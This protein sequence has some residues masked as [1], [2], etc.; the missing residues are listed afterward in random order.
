MNTVL[1]LIEHDRTTLFVIGI[2][3]YRKFIDIKNTNN[4]N[5]IFNQS[6]SNI[7]NSNNNLFNYI[8]STIIKNNKLLGDIIGFLIIKKFLRIICKFIFFIQFK[9]FNELFNEI[10]SE[11]VYNLRQIPGISGI[12]EKEFKKVEDDLR[13][14]LKEPLGDPK[15]RERIYKLPENGIPQDI[16]IKKMKEFQVKEDKVWKNGYVSGGIYHGGDNILDLQCEAY[17]M[18]TISNPLHADLWPSVLKYEAEIISMTAN[19]LNGGDVRVCGVMSSGGTESIFMATK[20]HREW[21]KR[22]F[23][24]TKPEIICG[25]TAHA[26]I[27]KACEILNI[28]LIQAPVDPITR[29][30]NVD[31]VRKRITK[32]TIMIYSSAPC[33]PSGIIDDIEDLSNLA[34]EYGIG[35][36]VDCCLGGFILPFARKLGQ[37]YGIPKFDFE[38]GGVTSMSVDT[39]KYGYAPKGTSVVLYR[40]KGIRKY[41]YFTY[42]QWSGG[43]YVTPGT[44]GSRSGA[45]S[46]GAWATMLTLG[47]KGYLECTKKILDETK[48]I[49]EAVNNIEG[50]DVLGDP[51]AMIVAFS[52]NKFNIYTFNDLL[53]KKGWI[54][55]ALQFPASIHMC[56]TYKSAPYID[57]FIK[58]LQEC[59]IIML[60]QDNSSAKTG[61]APIYG[62]ASALPP[63]PIASVLESYVD[64]TLEV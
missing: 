3:L 16:V 47:E 48:K 33:F 64:V 23:N 63:G 62:M 46:A 2:I 19:L 31:A 58:D 60:K 45:L 57:Q 61:S 44:P 32:D 49:K 43:L 39:H 22:E 55:N 27:D 36:H 20:A 41:Q 30:V 51:K 18:Y 40:H 9:T 53:H 13:K 56:V 6:D 34:Q 54:L 21:F 29:K 26:A 11:V 52:S 35:L 15:T 10:M 1:S 4:V 25:Q 12:I 28:K 37:E 5:Q 7:I 38:L 24:I 8:N 17:K 42:P 59:A 14:D 50:L